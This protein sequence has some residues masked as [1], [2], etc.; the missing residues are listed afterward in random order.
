MQKKKKK[1]RERRPGSFYYMNDADGD[2]K[3][4]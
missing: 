3:G 4:S 1:N 2:R